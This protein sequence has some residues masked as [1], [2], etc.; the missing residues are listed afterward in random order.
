[1][2]REA[3][4]GKAGQNWEELGGGA[5]DGYNN[6]HYSWPDSSFLKLVAKN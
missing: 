2:E 5:L 3:G 6:I 1:M 4:K